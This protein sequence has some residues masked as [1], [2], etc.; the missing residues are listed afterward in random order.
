MIL[1]HE[2]S[3]QGIVA[4]RVWLAPVSSTDRLRNPRQTGPVEQNGWAFHTAAVIYVQTPSGPVLYVIDPAVGGL[5]PLDQWKAQLTSHQRGL[6]TR[7][8]F[9]HYAQMEGPRPLSNEDLRHYASGRRRGLS[10][11]DINLDYSRKVLR[12]YRQV[13]DSGR[14][15][16]ASCSRCDEL[17]ESDLDDLAAAVRQNRQRTSGTR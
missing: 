15:V 13:I 6:Q 3:Q 8:T 10:A 4:A 16:E 1:G 9:H 7:M 12:H 11:L 5:Q 14:Q 17:R 2:L